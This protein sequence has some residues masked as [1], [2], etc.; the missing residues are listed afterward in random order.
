[1]MTSTENIDDWQVALFA[2]LPSIN[3]ISGLSAQIENHSLVGAK[4]PSALDNFPSFPVYPRQMSGKF[5]L[6]FSYPTGTT[7]K[8]RP[9]AGFRALRHVM[10]TERKKDVRS[11]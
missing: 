9:G 10:N 5:P 11:H 2:E 6:L 7:E 8:D 3:P 1:M 4:F